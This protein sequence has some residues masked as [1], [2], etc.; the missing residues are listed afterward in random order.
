MQTARPVSSN[1]DLMIC[2]FSGKDVMPL[3]TDDEEKARNS[4]KGKVRTVKIQVD[5]SDLIN[6]VTGG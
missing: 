5:D 3:I 2:G 1:S 4:A 6:L